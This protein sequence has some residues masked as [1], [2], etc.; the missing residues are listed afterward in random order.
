MGNKTLTPLEIYKELPKTNCKQCLLPSCL[1]FSA[2][3][4]AG[5]KKLG[6]CPFLPNE[7]VEKMSGHLKKRSENEPA[8]AEFIDKLE[9]KITKIDFE[10]RA[11]VIGAKVYQEKLSV[12]CLGK[13]FF[14]DQQG[15]I[16]SEC[17]IIPWVQVPILAYITNKTHQNITGEWI[18]F[19]E[20]KGGI[21]WQGLFSRR[22]EEPLKR[23]AQSHSGLFEDLVELFQGVPAQGFEADIAIILYP[24]PHV[25]IMI[26]FQAAEE[27]IE[28][29]VTI[30]FDA[31]CHKNLHI[32]SLFT[33]CAGLVQMFDQIAKRHM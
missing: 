20:I 32:K 3:V 2:A 27:D 33:L 13:D 22:C 31:S 21:D 14:V 17:H 10:K 23:L 12:N 8:Q 7:V 18:T 1:A 26:N 30:F 9:K 5:D 24:L 25:P 6:D 4:I 11:L 29:E 28:S 15:K 16:S 19:R